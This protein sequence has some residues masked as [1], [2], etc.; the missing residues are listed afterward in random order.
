MITLDRVTTVQ[1]DFRLPELSLEIPAGQYAVLMGR[2]GC[3][4]TTVL[5]I[6]CGL[7][8]VKGGR[9]LLDGRDVTALP[10]GRRGLG[11]VPQDG[12]LFSTMTV[13]D[14]LSFA[15][16]V[17]RW[18][19]PAR[20]E[21]VAELAAMLGVEHL[22]KRYPEKLS[23]GERQRVALG[24]ALAFRPPVLLLDEPLGALDDET[25]EQ[26]YDV[27]KDVR[28]RTGVTV[29]HV[30]HNREDALHLADRLLRLRDGRLSEE[31]LPR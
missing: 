30:T 31:S 22:L 1:G 20:R 6:V 7:R 28:Q 10:P 23:G 21:R 3:G 14:H 16:D 11:Y 25:R 8:R 13:R 27:L 4:K 12:A 9:V 17:A 2:T 24:R 18:P 26:M 5:E 15:L 19:R 29:L